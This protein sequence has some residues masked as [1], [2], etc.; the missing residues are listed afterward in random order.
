MFRCPKLR[1]LGIAVAAALLLTTGARAD[2]SIAQWDTT[3]YAGTE[4]VVT[5]TQMATDVTADD[6]SRSTGLVPNA[7][8]NNYNSANWSLG[9]YVQLGFTTTGEWDV[10]S[11]LLATRSSA[12]GPGFMDVNASVDG[13]AFTQ[14]GQIIQPSATYVDQLLTFSSVLDVH[15][16]LVI[17]FTPDNNTAANGGTIGQ[18]G[19][20]RIGD[21]ESPQGV[22]SPITLSGVAVPEP[23]SLVV[24]G[25]ALVC[26][27]VTRRWRRNVAA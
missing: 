4:A 7:G 27:G 25:V 16:S 6:I 3:G 15:S 10:T 17:Q 20:W 26:L 18:F 1:A 11:L 12:T 23:S 2:V 13:G 9:Q 22:F 8:A 19:T 21:Y 5:P 14:I 24:C